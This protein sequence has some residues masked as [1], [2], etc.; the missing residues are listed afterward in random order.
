MDHVRVLYPTSRRVLI[1]DA[2]SGVDTNQVLRVQTGT[3]LFAL[4]GATDCRPR[5]IIVVVRGTTPLSPQ[6]IIFLPLAGFPPGT[7]AGDPT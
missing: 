1:D 3:H 7:S 4:D 2:D 6:E 5:E